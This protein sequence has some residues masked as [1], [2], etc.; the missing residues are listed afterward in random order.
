[1]P[2]AVIALMLPS[3]S[4]SPARTMKV[5]RSGPC[6]MA[7]NPL[8]SRTTPLTVTSPMSSPTDLP[9]GWTPREILATRHEADERIAAALGFV[10]VGLRRLV[11]PRPRPAPGLTSLAAAGSCGSARHEGADDHATMRTVMHPHV[12]LTG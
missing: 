10:G 11:R 12:V 4:F 2:S 7:M 6:T 9:D 1:M 8:R 5:F 3:I